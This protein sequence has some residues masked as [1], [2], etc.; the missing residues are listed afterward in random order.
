VVNELGELGRVRFLVTSG[1]ATLVVGPAADRVAIDFYCDGSAFLRPGPELATIVLGIPI[2]VGSGPVS[3]RGKLA[4]KSWTTISAATPLLA[5]I[6][7][8]R[9]S[10]D[11]ADEPR[12]SVPTGGF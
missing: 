2:T 1:T 8:F 6:E 9:G 3:I 7:Y 12:T 5:T 4:T 10:E 11:V